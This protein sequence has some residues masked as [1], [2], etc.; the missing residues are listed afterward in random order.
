MLH[1]VRYFIGSMSCFRI[2]IAP[3]ASISKLIILW[4]KIVVLIVGFETLQRFV[5][6]RLLR[7]WR[8]PKGQWDGGF[9]SFQN[10][11]EFTQRI[12]RRK[13]AD[14]Q[15]WLLIRLG[16]LVLAH[17]LVLLLSGWSLQ[18]FGAWLLDRLEVTFDFLRIIPTFWGRTAIDPPAK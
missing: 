16:C 11:W 3:N 10:D 9:F 4:H 6:N 14:R 1:S 8:K 5:V 17:G 18:T 15:R 13:L 12:A 7:W 2:S